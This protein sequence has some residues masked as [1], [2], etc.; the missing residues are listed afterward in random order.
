ML[1]KR[2][3]RIFFKQLSPVKHKLYPPNDN[4]QLHFQI[5]SII[6]SKYTYVSLY[7]NYDIYQCQSSGLHKDVPVFR[8]S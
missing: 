4:G 7:Q 3:D 1:V 6:A 8:F 2:E 5:F